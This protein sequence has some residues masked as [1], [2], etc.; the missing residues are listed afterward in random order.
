M[1]SEYFCVGKTNSGA[2][3]IISF[4]DDVEDQAE[5]LLI[6][7]SVSELFDVYSA[8]QY[9]SLHEYRGEGFETEHCLFYV[10]MSELTRR[11]IKMTDFEDCMINKR[12]LTCIDIANYGRTL[13][14]K[15]YL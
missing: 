14:N 13:V 9:L 3:I 4:M 2:S 1:S 5:R 10:R 15:I 12:L 7:F 8:I 6:K 11:S